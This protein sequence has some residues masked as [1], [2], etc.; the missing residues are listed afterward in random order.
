M[1]DIVEGTKTDVERC[2]AIARSLPQYFTQKALEAM[3]KDLASHTFHVARDEFGQVL[4]FASVR[5]STEL[6]AELEWLAVGVRVESR[7]ARRDPD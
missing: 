3:R 7:R 2:I 5:M 6:A 4:G 1:I